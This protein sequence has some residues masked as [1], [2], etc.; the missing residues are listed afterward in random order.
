MAPLV[1][2]LKPDTIVS[3]AAWTAVDL[4]ENEPVRARLANAEAPG[5]LARAA[6]R[7][8]A[9]LIH[10]STDYVFD[11]K[12]N[13][14]Y[15]ESDRTNPQS[16]YGRTKLEGEEQVRDALAE[17]VILRTAWIYSPF[18]RNFV[19]TMLSFADKHD[20]V[21]VVEDQVGN[22]TSA[23]DLAD[24]VFTVLARWRDGSTDG[25]GATY[26]CAGSGEAN[27]ASLARHAFRASREA[28]GPFTRVEGIP[29]SAWPTK[30]ERPR[31]SQLD[32]GLFAATFGLR[33]P[34]W[35][36]SVDSTVSRLLTP[37]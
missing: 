32:C 12:K 10:I 6:N 5:E 3:V 31:N 11:G 23:L 15:A 24:A 22:P 25:M 28:G 1:E 26:H 18:G 35:R 16:V 33:L 9:R 19:K 21:R 2:R 4:A 14:P 36:G 34:D 37:I 13:A 30:A 8:G 7:I 20:S 29:S 17:H 27:W